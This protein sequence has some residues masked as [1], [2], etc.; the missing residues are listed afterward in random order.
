MWNHFY[1]YSGHTTTTDQARQPNSPITH[2]SLPSEDLLSWLF[3]NSQI[4]SGGYRCECSHPPLTDGCHLTFTVGHEKCEEECHKST[5]KSIHNLDKV[6]RSLILLST[7]TSFSS[8]CRGGAVP[9]PQFVTLWHDLLSII[10]GDVIVICST[11]YLILFILAMNVYV[12]LMCTV[13]LSYNKIWFYN[14]NGDI[15]DLNDRQPRGLFG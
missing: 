13:S 11:T 2:W 14:D 3:A 10:V 8:V 5:A 12:L 9:S 1:K 4:K 7:V 6:C 15:L